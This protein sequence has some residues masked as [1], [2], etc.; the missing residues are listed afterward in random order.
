MIDTVIINAK[1]VTPRE[2][3]HG[4]IAIDEGKIQLVGP[5]FL[6]PES[7]E[8][9]DAQ[10]GFVIPGL[11]DPHVHY[12][13]VGPEPFVERVKRDWEPDGI[14]ALFGG[15]TTTMPMLMSPGAYAPMIRSLIDW[16]EHR[17]ALDFGFTIVVH[18]EEHLGEFP[19]LYEQGVTSFK[20]F[21]TAFKGAEGEQIDLASVDEGRLF[22]SLEL[23]RDLGAPAVA[24]V[25]AEDC[26][27][28]N[29]FIARVRAKGRDGLEAWADARPQFAEFT[30]AE[31]AS[32]LAHAAKAPVYFV[33][34][35]TR[36]SMEVLRKYKAKGTQVS[37]EAVIHTLTVSRHDD[38]G[39]WGKFAPPLRGWEDIHGVWEGLRSGAIDTV[40]S[41]HC[42]Y[43]LEQKEQ[44]QGKHG[45]I[46]DI[47]PG[48][49]NNQEHMLPGLWT[50]GVKKGRLAV[51]DVVRLCS[52]NPAR[53]FGLYPRK[54][55]IIMGA[56]ADLVIVDDDTEVSV[57][58]SFYHGRDPRFSVYMGRRL[59]G[60]PRL[61]MLRGKVVVRD[62]KYLGSPGDGRFAPS[63]PS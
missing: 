15:V 48:I 9:I 60:R 29:I 38:V 22:R 44:G 28:Y 45:S 13:L 21:F 18:R 27:I 52:E 17:S 40:A 23:I 63:R 7:R 26:D 20:H 58:P 47:P 12:G 11:V 51:H 49:N 8:L 50:E 2:I 19:R 6:M 43:T 42:T 34:L 59:V 41:D 25:H 14:G 56:D 62:G 36:E 61:T 54:G 1:V 30:R 16:G 39:I 10:D 37:G 5:R 53:R 31:F 33:H 46:W 55:A 32:A 3:S 24:M 4:C 35:T 57:D